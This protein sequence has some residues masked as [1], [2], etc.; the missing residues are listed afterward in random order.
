MID[1]ATVLASKAVL[2][3]WEQLS[4]KIFLRLPR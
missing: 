1:A 2:S 3:L 4:L